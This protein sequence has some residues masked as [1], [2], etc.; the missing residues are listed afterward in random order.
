MATAHCGGHT[1]ELPDACCLCAACA[2]VCAASR[3]DSLSHSI[4]H[5][6]LTGLER[7]ITKIRGWL[8]ML[9]VSGSVSHPSSKLEIGSSG[10]I[11]VALVYCMIS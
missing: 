11:M 3:L 6:V 7:E 8:A 1:A 2:R 5:D 9:E 10:L 4:S